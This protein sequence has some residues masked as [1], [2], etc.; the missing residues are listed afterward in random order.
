MGSLS[1]E[2]RGNL[3]VFTQVN[4]RFD[5]SLYQ[6]YFGFREAV[7]SRNLSALSFSLAKSCEC[8]KITKSSKRI[9]D[10]FV[11][12]AERDCPF[13][14]VFLKTKSRSSFNHK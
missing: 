2:P 12:I 4:Y 8:Y 9:E 5:T 14:L 11:A 1:Y 6:E 13:C 10:N 7:S 3:S